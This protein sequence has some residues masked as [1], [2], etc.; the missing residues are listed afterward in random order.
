M[1]WMTER[2]RRWHMVFNNPSLTEPELQFR[3]IA[4]GTIEFK[5]LEGYGFLNNRNI[6]EE[7]EL[8]YIRARS[9]I[10]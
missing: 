4:Q 7:I 8:I 3:K 1:R 2:D 10:K 6:F 9:E 5:I